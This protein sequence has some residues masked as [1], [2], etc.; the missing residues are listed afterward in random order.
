MKNSLGPGVITADLYHNLKELTSIILK[1]SHDIESEG[2]LLP[3]SFYE[4]IF[5]SFQ[6]WTRIQAQKQNYRPISLMI[7]HAKILNKI[8][9]N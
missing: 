9:S 4:A 6:N 2:T 7:M 1:L 5:H 8:L 3:N